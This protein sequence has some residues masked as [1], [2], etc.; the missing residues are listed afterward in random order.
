MTQEWS[1]TPAYTA[2]RP[3]GRGAI[4]TGVVLLVVGIVLGVVGIVGVVSSMSGLISGFG[5]PQ[6]TP[7]TISRVLEGGTT[8]AVYE[9][10]TAGSRSGGD[11]SV[12]SVTSSDVT[13]TDPSGQPVAVAGPGL[14]T[15]TYTNNARTFDAVAMFTATT[16]GVTAFTRALGWVSLIGLGALAGLVGLIT[17]I[18]G[19]VRRSSSRRAVATPSHATPVQVSGTGYPGDAATAQPYAA[20]T[21]TPTP[22]PTPAG[23]PA[24]AEPPA[25]P[26]VPQPVAPPALPPAA[27]YPD[28]ERPGGQRYWDGAA[29]TEHRA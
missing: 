6:V 9:T 29:W 23:Q 4:I 8:Y 17:L 2:P 7:V 18:V 22:T 3:K 25:Q 11:G 20:P 13:V 12:G 21:P 5:A 14:M 24:L 19:L 28:P 26:P 1:L 16:T 15:Q 27:W 10:P